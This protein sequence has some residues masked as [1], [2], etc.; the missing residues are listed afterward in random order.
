M[1]VSCPGCGQQYEKPFVICVN[2]GLNIKTGQR[3][4]LQVGGQTTADD[5][6]DDIDNLDETDERGPGV[7]W[8]ALQWTAEYLP[9][10]F[11]PVLLICAILL[12]ALGLVIIV[13]GVFLM[14]SM[15]V[16]GSLAFLAVGSLAY[17]QAVSWVVYGGFELL[18]EALA[19]FDSTRWFLW[20]VGLLLP[21]V[22]LFALIYFEVITAK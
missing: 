7:A 4:A 15:V 11:R 2:C 8:R 16:L 19:D 17:A 3:L 13:V 22:T 10:L 14:L 5:D 6:A 21:G 20:F 12:A 9:G 18:T 1:P